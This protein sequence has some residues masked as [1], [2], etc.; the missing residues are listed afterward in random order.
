MLGFVKKGTRFERALKQAKGYGPG[1]PE[2]LHVIKG[3]AKPNR[4]MIVEVIEKAD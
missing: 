4:T 1:K 3:V 2:E